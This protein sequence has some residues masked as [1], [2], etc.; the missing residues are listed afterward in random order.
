M[1]IIGLG[2]S[3]AGDD[4]VGPLVARRLLSYQSSSVRILEG[5]LAGL[6]LLHEMK[7]TETLVLI[8]SVYSRSDP[9]T[10]VRFTI[11]RDLKTIGN[12][13]WGPS[14]PSTHTFGIGEALTLAEILE[15][16][17]EQVILYGIEVD[18]VQPGRS[19]SP[20]VS[21]S[22]QNVVRQI[23]T[24][25]LNIPPQDFHPKKKTKDSPVVNTESCP[26]AN[27]RPFQRVL[28]EEKGS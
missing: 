4:A 16:L 6:N 27:E 11:P 9:G 17:P 19:L 22:I 23:V 1:T 12:L 26:V 2:N 28:G 14:T 21:R 18:H 7:K 8:D 24:V 25:D 5:G 3:L 13:T 20:P 15:M 10:I